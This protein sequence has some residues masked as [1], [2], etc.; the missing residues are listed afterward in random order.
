VFLIFT[1]I[2]PTISQ[3]FGGY[4]TW[5]RIIVPVIV[6]IYFFYYLTIGRRK[7]LSLEKD[8]TNVFVN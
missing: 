5:I 6:F 8:K 7:Y 3:S 2:T 1:F 4:G